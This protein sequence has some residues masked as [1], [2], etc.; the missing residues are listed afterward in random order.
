MDNTKSLTKYDSII[1]AAVSI[2]ITVVGNYFNRLVFVK[3]SEGFLVFC[4]CFWVVQILAVNILYVMYVSRKNTAKKQRCSEPV[5][6]K[7]ER[8]GGDLQSYVI[9]EEEEP[10]SLGCYEF[11]FNN[12]VYR[13]E[14]FSKETFEK[15]KNGSAILYVNPNCPREFIDPQLNRKAQA[16]VLLTFMRVVLTAYGIFSLLYCLQ[17]VA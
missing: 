4:C 11:T 16:A 14:I 3:N 6:A 5:R 13:S 7:V 1:Y 9:D 17:I 12:T 10:Q 8:Y 2:L 15:H